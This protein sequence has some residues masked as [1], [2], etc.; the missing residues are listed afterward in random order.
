V[1]GC[2]DH[3]GHYVYVFIPDKAVVRAEA[4]RRGLDG[5]ATIHRRNCGQAVP[6]GSVRVGVVGVSCGPS[7]AEGEARSE[8]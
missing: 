8:N 3:V 5:V 4:R 7:G 6:R 1:T 2:T